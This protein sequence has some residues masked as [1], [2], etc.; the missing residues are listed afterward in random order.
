MLKTYMEQAKATIQKDVTE[1]KGDSKGHGWTYWASAKLDNP[2][3]LN[4]TLRYALRDHSSTYVR[5]IAESL[6]QATSSLYFK[7]ID[8]GY[9]RISSLLTV[10]AKEVD[11]QSILQ[12]VIAKNEVSLSVHTSLPVEGES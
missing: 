6:F 3:V 9:R 5:G 2:T 11:R 8:G 10:K 7:N 4:R 12:V 1:G